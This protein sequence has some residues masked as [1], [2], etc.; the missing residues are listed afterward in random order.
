MSAPSSDKAR[1]EASR[2][3]AKADEDA[4]S[5]RVLIDAT[6]PRPATAAYLY[7]QAAEKLMKG[8]LTR[9]AAQ[10]HK[11]HNL[12]ELA[13]QVDNSHP[14]LRRLVALLRWQTSWNVV[15]RY[16]R[17]ERTAE[18]APTVAELLAVFDDIARLRAKRRDRIARRG[19]E[20]DGGR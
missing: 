18:P 17:A 13:G 14:E 16:P 10:F 19:G 4:A 2:R 20:Q 5:A 3:L 7:Q 8:R 1:E 15:F 11:T 6:P 12:D 9:A